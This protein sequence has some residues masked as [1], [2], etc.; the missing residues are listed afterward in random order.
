MCLQE[1]AL[2][3]KEEGNPANCH[4]IDGT[5]VGGTSD[6]WSKSHKEREIL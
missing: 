1:I 2:R 6:G 3:N 4:N 5:L